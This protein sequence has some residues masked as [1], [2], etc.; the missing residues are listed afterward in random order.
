MNAAGEHR[1]RQ[2]FNRLFQTFKLLIS[3]LCPLFESHKLE[4]IRFSGR[5]G[6]GESYAG[7]ATKIQFGNSLAGHREIYTRY[8]R[9]MKI[10]DDLLSMFN[11]ER[12][13]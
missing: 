10:Q 11:K 1:L 12:W 4:S 8:L 13:S 2:N 3:S 6:H 7:A 9:W 5:I